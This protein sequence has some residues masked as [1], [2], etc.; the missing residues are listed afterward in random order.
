MKSK[1]VFNCWEIESSTPSG[2]EY[3]PYSDLIWVRYDKPYSIFYC[4]RGKKRKKYL[5]LMSLKKISDKLPPVFFRC[6]QSTI[7]NIRHLHRCDAIK[8]ALVM[9]DDTS[10]TLP[11]RKKPVFIAYKSFVEKIE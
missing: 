5:V 10:F 11:R 4:E 7:V 2:I 3:Y 8:S 9:D 6:N 1:I